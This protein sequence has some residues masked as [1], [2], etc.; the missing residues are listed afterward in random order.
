M[1]GSSATIVP[2]ANLL[3]ARDWKAVRNKLVDYA[4]TREP[5]SHGIVKWNAK[6]AAEKLLDAIK[7]GS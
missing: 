7:Q 3:P 4:Q 5:H 1:A 2:R 6:Y